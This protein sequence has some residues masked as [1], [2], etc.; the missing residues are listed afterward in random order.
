MLYYSS[1]FFVVFV[2]IIPEISKKNTRKKSYGVIT[3]IETLD[4]SVAPNSSN[5][6]NVLVDEESPR[7]R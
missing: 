3:T 4:R 7:E 5:I 2:L 6:T 1:L